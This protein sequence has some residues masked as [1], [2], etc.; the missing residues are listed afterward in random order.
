VGRCATYL[1]PSRFFAAP[2]LAPKSSEAIGNFRRRTAPYND[3]VKCIRAAI[4]DRSEISSGYAFKMDG[5]ADTLL[6][7]AEWVSMESL[8]IEMRS[9]D[10]ELRDCPPRGFGFQTKIPDP[11]KLPYICWAGA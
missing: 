2:S 10:R 1:E 4:R 3:L 7:A 5:K 6:E 8:C 11:T 9:L